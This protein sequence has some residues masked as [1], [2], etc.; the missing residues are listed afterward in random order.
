MKAPLVHP[1]PRA[2]DSTRHE[3]EHPA[4]QQRRLPI[5]SEPVATGGTHFRAWA[6][7]SHC[8]KVELSDSPEWN[9]MREFELFPEPD[10]Y[11]S[12]QVMEATPGMLYRYKLE[13]GSFPDP[14]S[15]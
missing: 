14:A 6:P 9:S 3:E 8:V 15:R 10:G 2:A 13:T 4:A 11:F 1:L 12:G 7:K 5:G